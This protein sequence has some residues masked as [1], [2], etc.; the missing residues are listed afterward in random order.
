ML[1]HQENQERIST[2]GCTD[3]WL[4]MERQK[5][6]LTCFHR[7]TASNAENMTRYYRYGMS[8][9]KHTRTPFHSCYSPVLCFKARGNDGYGNCN[10]ERSVIGDCGRHVAI[11]ALLLSILYK[12]R[13][14]TNKQCSRT[15][16]MCNEQRVTNKINVDLTTKHFIK[17]NIRYSWN[18]C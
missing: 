10:C 9:I 1:N 17:N 7:W 12:W 18:S 3:K 2:Y 4:N 14:R 5:S 15:E 6:G 16:Q 8:Q 13:P 11:R